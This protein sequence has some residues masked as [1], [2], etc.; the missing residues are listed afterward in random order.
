MG[1][2][3]ATV[4][5]LFLL[6]VTIQMLSGCDLQNRMLYFPEAA[7][8]S[9]DTLK[10]EYLMP[11]PPAEEP[12]G[13]LSGKA[14]TRAK[15]IVVLFHGNAG[16]AVDRAFYGEA[17]ATLGYRVLLAEYP[18]Y[19]GRKGT[20]GET[21]FVADALETVRLAFTQ[22]G[23]PLFLLGES[24]GCGVAAAVTKATSVPLDGVI[25]ITPWE[26]LAAVAQAK[27][28]WLPVRLLLTDT[29]DTIGNLTTFRG[30]VAVIGAE[31]DEV[32][33]LRHAQAL[34]N[35]LPGPAKRLW[36]LPGAGHNDWL[37]MTTP[38]WW[39]ELMDFISHNEKR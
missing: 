18:R 9:E 27:F 35:A 33:P 19:G 29:Y 30:K 28:P 4:R 8:P 3:A 25:L 7:A 39:Q 14:P 31:R 13:Y 21:A 1:V 10:R 20:L 16:T 12:R 15:G 36:I 24:L 23:G 17:L 37:R 34:Y 22:F 6:F 38:L 5:R 26:T 32:I 2:D 11:W